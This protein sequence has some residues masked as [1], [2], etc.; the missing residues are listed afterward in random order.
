MLGLWSL[1][2]ILI[3]HGGPILLQE[4][5]PVLCLMQILVAILQNQKSALCEVRQ[6]ASS[7]VIGYLEP[8]GMVLRIPEL[9]IEKHYPWLRIPGTCLM[10]WVDDWILIYV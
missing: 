10:A 6:Q 1:L 2:E 7:F 4:R 8:Y 9:N 5:F 3:P